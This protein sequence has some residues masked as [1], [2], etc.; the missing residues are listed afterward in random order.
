MFFF[1]FFSP[2][3]FEETFQLC[4]SINQKVT[5]SPLCV[6]PWVFILQFNQRTPV[7]N[8]KERGRAPTPQ[9]PQK[10][11][12]EPQI[13]RSEEKQ[14]HPGDAGSQPAEGNGNTKTLGLI[15]PRSL[16][17]FLS[18]YVHCKLASEDS[19]VFSHPAKER[20]EDRPSWSPQAKA[21]N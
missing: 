3:V 10:I 14:R 8:A 15:L 18:S 1:F 11:C 16:I 2:N 12:P 5:V 21:R 20:A 19:L 6:Q 13:R 9:K 4:I 7:N 17:C